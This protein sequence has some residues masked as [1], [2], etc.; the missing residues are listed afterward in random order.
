ML[1]WLCEEGAQAYDLGARN[2]YKQRWAEAGLATLGLV[3]RPP[4]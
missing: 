2:E 3:L 4:A 1:S